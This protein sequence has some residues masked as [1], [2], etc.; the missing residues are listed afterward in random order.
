MIFITNN[1]VNLHNKRQK[2]IL[3]VMIKFTFI[4]VVVILCKKAY[5]LKGNE[6]NRVVIEKES[7]LSI[8]KCD[9]FMKLYILIIIS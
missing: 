2:G 5:S 9:S 1:Y 6:Y 4:L 3:L 7:H 8:D